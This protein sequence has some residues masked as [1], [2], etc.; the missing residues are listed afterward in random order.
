MK[1]LY[2]WIIKVFTS[3][4]GVEWRGPNADLHRAVQRRMAV[5]LGDS[6]D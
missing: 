4:Q 1:T 6:N 3:N 5:V 2:N